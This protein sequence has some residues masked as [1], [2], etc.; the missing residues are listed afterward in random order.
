MVHFFAIKSLRGRHVSFV[1][2]T[3]FEDLYFDWDLH[4]FLCPDL[5]KVNFASHVRLLKDGFNVKWDALFS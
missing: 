4:K 5:Q 3:V 1:K 2:D